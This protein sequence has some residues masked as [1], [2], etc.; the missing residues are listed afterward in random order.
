MGLLLGVASVVVITHA[1]AVT[2]ETMSPQGEVA[3]VR[4][5]RLTFSDSMVKFGDPRLP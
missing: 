5:A 4:Q 2:V 3:K 1:L